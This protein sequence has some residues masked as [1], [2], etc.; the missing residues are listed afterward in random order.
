M[1]NTLHSARLPSPSGVSQSSSLSCLLSEVQSA[2]DALIATCMTSC[3]L[4]SM[5]SYIGLWY[6]LIVFNMHTGL[7]LGLSVG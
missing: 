2:G 5:S 1:W 7:W 3:L 4:P 6:L